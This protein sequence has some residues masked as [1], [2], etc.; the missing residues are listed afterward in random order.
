MQDDDEAALLT[1]SYSSS[2]YVSA[3]VVYITANIRAETVIISNSFASH[4]L[5]KSNE[6]QV[7]S[8]YIERSMV[9]FIHKVSILSLLLAVL[10]VLEVS[11]FA[12][13]FRH[14]VLAAAARTASLRHAPALAMGALNQPPL[15]LCEENAELVMEE[16]RRE[17]GTIFGYDDKSKEVGITGELRACAAAS[18]PPLAAR[19]SHAA[20][21]QALLSRVHDHDQS[22]LQ[23]HLIE[24]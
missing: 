20:R 2:C 3:A 17:L 18:L 12:S 5:A 11:T 7:T 14:N 23:P 4:N 6:K 19:L 21:K 8:I 15:E 9:V 13:G 22:D 24:E 1:F 16:V 10:V